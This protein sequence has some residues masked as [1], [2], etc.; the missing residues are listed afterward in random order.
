MGR[1]QG[2]LELGYPGMEVSCG[3]EDEALSLAAFENLIWADLG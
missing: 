2:L 3:C 1:R